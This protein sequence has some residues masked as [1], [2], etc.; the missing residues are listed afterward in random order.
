MAHCLF[1][2]DPCSFIEKGIGRIEKGIELVHLIEG[3]AIMGFWSRKIKIYIFSLFMQQYNV[4]CKCLV[5][6]DLEE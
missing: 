5:Y 1:S 4:C 2:R 3:E 6:I